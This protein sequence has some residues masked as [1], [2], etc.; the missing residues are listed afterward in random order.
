V[1]Y[2]VA[3]ANIAAFRSFNRFHTRL[4]GALNDHLL[5]SDYSLPQV[6]VLYELATAPGPLAAIDLGQMLGMDKGFLSRILSRLES[7]GLIVRNS[8]AGN[9]KRL[10]LSLTTAGRKVFAALDRRSASEARQ[11][12]D[13]LRPA[14][15]ARLAH[16]LKD[17]QR[18][19]AGAPE[20][21]TFREPSPGDIAKVVSQQAALYAAEYGWNAEYEALAM[22]I[23]A[24]FIREFRPGRERCWIAEMGGAIVGAVFLVLVSDD[25]A[26]LRLLHVEPHARGL[27]IGR[28]LVEE[29]IA[30]ARGAGYRELVLWTN[31][32]LV[33]ARRI[34]EAAGFRLVAEERHHS[35]GKDLVGQNWRL[36]L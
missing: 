35:F 36:E 15:Q 24:R 29:C 3:D 19:L 1:P 8:S 33:S 32:V 26:K 17:A 23:A 12:L 5:Q 27:G 28:R 11:R 2:P 14:A 7:D 25:T 16:V 10:E 30:F 13:R 22:E 34:Y 4:V 9:A 6:R 20:E 21:V 31:D 18:L